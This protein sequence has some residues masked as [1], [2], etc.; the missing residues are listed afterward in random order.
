MPV[1]WFLCCKCPAR[2]VCSVVRLRERVLAIRVCCAIAR[3]FPAGSIRQR[4]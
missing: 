2:V 3:W 4:S 1:R